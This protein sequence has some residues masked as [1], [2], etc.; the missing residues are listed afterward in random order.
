MRVSVIFVLLVLAS[1]HQAEEPKSEGPAHYDYILKKYVAGDYF[2]YAALHKNKKDR[3]RLDAF[4]KWQAKADLS[5]MSREEQ[6][7]FY[8]N[9]Y[10]SCCIQAILDRYPVHSPK[11]IDGFFDKIKFTVAGEKLTIS[12][13]EYNRLIANY[14]DM[15]AHFAVVCSDR[16]CLPLKKGAY[17]GKTLKADLDAAALRFLKDERQFKVDQKNK[18]IWISKI[19]DWYGPK[20]TKDPK[21]PAKRPEEYLKYWASDRVK[22]LLESGKYKVKFIEWDWTLNE[23]HKK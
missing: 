19:F 12:G 22:K 3:A 2:N 9:A 5:R 13:I 16:G 18:V 21:R 10:N 6:I 15:R 23:K 8:I 7:A 11:D 17:Q 20:F 1:I 4:M 14:K